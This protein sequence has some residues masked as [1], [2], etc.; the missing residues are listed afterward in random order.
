MIEQQTFGLI[1]LRAQFYPVPVLEMMGQHYR[2]DETVHM[3][4]FEYWLLRPVQ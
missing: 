3:N 2:V 1:I 4:G